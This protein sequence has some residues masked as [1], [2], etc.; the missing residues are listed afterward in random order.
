[1]IIRG[2]AAK[3][4]TGNTSTLR[5][6]GHSIGNPACQDMCGTDEHHVEDM[7]QCRLYRS[8]AHV[9]TYVASRNEVII[10]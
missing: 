4:L 5:C 8:E 9:D 7:A 6:G 10:V 2:R 3:L 1:M